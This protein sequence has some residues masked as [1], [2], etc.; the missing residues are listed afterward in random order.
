VRVLIAPDKFR[1]TL[2]ARQAAEA[3]AAGWRRRRPTDQLD[4]APVA[5][6]GEGTTEAVVGAMGGELVR[7]G[8]HGP[9]GD[10]LDASFG[11]ARTANGPLAVVESAAASGLQLLPERRRDPRRTST[12]GTGELIA[13]ALGRRPRTC[14]V[15][16]GGSATNDGGA[17]MAQALGVRL[18]DAA[19]GELAAG[20]ASLLQLV[21]IDASGIDPGIADVTVV[22]ATDVDNP[23]VGAAGASAVYGPQKGASPE[24]VALL[25][26]ALGHLA[27]VVARDLGVDLRNEPGAGAAGGLGFGLMAFVGARVRS[28]VDVI[29]E[30]LDLPSRAAAADLVIT[31]EGRFDAQSLRGKAPAG[32]LRLA[33]EAGT[34]AVVVCGDAE[35]GVTVPGVTVR[36]LVARFGPDGAMGDARRSVELVAEELADRADALA[37]G[38]A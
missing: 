27:A 36:S 1:G 34:A 29:A 25:D 2:S 33:R 5:D 10:P 9:L 13:A 18:L 3:L 38:A 23:L 12:R 32:V 17:G 24:D 14:V 26:G 16:L 37:R 11:F 22:A 20:G 30:V 15:G 19:G 8:V 4:L 6:G 7:V 21:R 35:P 31:G 28:G